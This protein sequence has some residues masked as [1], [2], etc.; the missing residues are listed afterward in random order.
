[1]TGNNKY[2]AVAQNIINS[3]KKYF[4]LLFRLLKIP[5]VESDIWSLLTEELPTNQNLMMA[6]HD[7]TQVEDSFKF[8]YW[9][10]LLGN[11]EAS[12]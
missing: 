5:D 8:E 6:I 7:C 4:E 2:A 1:M 9:K 11:I 10:K 12:P 3:N